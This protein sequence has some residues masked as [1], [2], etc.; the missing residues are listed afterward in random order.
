M[1]SKNKRV[2]FVWFCLTS[3]TIQDDLRA[4][5]ALITKCQRTK[6]IE[7]FMLTPTRG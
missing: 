1:L 5:H 3:S 2:S 7:N 6:N 4:N